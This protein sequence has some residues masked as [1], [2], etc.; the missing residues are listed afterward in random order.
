MRHEQPPLELSGKGVQETPRAALLFLLLPLV[1]S[2][3]LLL[4]THYTLDQDP[5]ELIWV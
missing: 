1:A 2:Q 4:K 3:R 5:K